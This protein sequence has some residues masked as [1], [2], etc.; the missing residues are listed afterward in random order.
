MSPR[1]PETTQSPLIPR[2][3]WMREN[4]PR[5]EEQADADWRRVT[6]SIFGASTGAAPKVVEE[7]DACEKFV[8]NWGNIISQETRDGEKRC[9][10]EW[11][12]RVRADK[13]RTFDKQRDGGGSPLRG[14]ET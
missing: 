1:S 11:S 7:K 3:Q 5:T 4:D 14:T 8:P 10:E 9:A 2:T 12:T 6:E 13:R